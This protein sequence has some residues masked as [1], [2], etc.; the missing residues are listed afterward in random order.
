MQFDVCE[1][2]RMKELM[3][4]RREGENGA[5]V[6]KAPLTVIARSSCLLMTAINI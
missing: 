3:H 2:M 6:K 1:V 4:W 5:L